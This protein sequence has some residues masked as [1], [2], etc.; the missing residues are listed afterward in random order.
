MLVD[1]S[2]YLIVFKSLISGTKE[3]RKLLPKEKMI[4]EK[5]SRVDSLSLVLSGRLIILI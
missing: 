3:I 4:E 2:L 1:M 5:I